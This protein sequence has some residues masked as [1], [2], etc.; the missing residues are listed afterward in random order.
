MGRASAIRRSRSIASPERRAAM[1]DHQGNPSPRDAATSGDR[2]SPVAQQIEQLQS[3][4][5]RLTMRN[6]P[7]AD[8]YHELLTRLVA[9]LGAHGGAVWTFAADGRLALA[10]QLD[11]DVLGPA[12][13]STDTDGHAALLSYVHT[14]GTSVLVQPGGTLNVAPAARNPTNYVLILVPLPIGAQSIAVLEIAQRP[15]TSN[16]A[17]AGYLS[18]LEQ[19]ANIMGDFHRRGSSIDVP[20]NEWRNHFART[21][22]ASLELRRTA[23]TIANEGRNLAGC[24]RLSVAVPVRR[25]F[26]VL[27]TSGQDIVHPRSNLALRLN[28][29]A[30]AAARLGEEVWHPDA[31]AELPPQVDEA[32]QDYLDETHVRTCGIVPLRAPTL[33]SPSAE[34]RMVGLLIADWFSGEG[35]DDRR[36]ARLRAVGE[37][38]TLALDNA[39]RFE[40]IPGISLWQA[41]GRARWM[42]AAKNLPKTV[43]AVALLAAGLLSLVLIPADFEMEARGKLEPVVRRAVF[44]RT[45]GVIDEVHAV[46]G[47]MVHQGDLL[48]LL[49]NTAFEYQLASISGELQTTSKKLAAAQ[50]SLLVIDRGTPADRSRYTQLAGEIEQLTTEKASLD[51][52]YSLLIAQ[53]ADLRVVSPIDGQVATWDVAG[54]LGNRPVERGQA[55]LSVA[56]TAGPWQLELLVPDRRIGHV[57]SAQQSLAKQLDVSFLLATDPAHSYQGHVKQVAMTSDVEPEAGAV[58]KVDVSI[59]RSALAEPRPGA[60]V[61]ARIHCGRRSLG[62][63][64]LH[65]V[66]EF[67]Q[68][69]VLFRL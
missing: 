53:K 29:L 9:A 52:R 8:Y 45:D 20:F 49:R 62:Y 41:L 46:H 40:A 17:Q 48:V 69:R 55:L 13:S 64:L 22:H 50:A 58:V 66:W 12:L 59:D 43:A 26:E 54:L 57:K 30:T 25:G 32:L 38:A 18:F 51:E 11:F 44:A 31:K 6:P 4:I 60:T 24:D 47:Q 14:S 42:L 34:G 65:E 15:N 33:D 10:G 27:S 3:E 23:Y 35:D 21:V 56:D 16:A 67:I 7:S 19:I 28:R 68:T 2:A 39:Q 5:V 36:R 37:H 61:I 1:T 63:V